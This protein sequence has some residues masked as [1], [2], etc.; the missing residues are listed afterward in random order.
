MV[1]AAV[2]SVAAAECAA[3]PASCLCVQHLNTLCCCYSA[4]LKRSS[5]PHHCNA[6][7]VWA[8]E[9]QP[10]AEG[11]AAATA[12]TPVVRPAATLQALASTLAAL[13]GCHLVLLRGRSPAGKPEEA[14][15][16]L[17]HCGRAFAAAVHLQSPGG[18]LP[19]RVGVMSTAEAAAAT[20]A[21]SGDP[22]S[23]SSVSL[24]A[25]SR[26]AVFQQLSAQA[27]AALEHFLQQSSN[28]GGGA[29]A[30][31]LE[32]LLLWLATCGDVF[33][34]RAAASDALL[35]AD[36][37]AGGAGLLPPLRRPYEGLGWEA[38]WAA[39][40]NPQLRSAEHL[41]TELA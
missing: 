18:L 40:L 13:P 15:T 37:A 35:L 30:S 6:D 38:L 7:A 14:S 28:C 20:A 39:A 16:V 24:W 29:A 4:D 21:G 33:T 26:H 17:L 27:A 22:L 3:G 5:S 36:P 31:A 10:Q 2:R 41:A 23:G 19:L 12:T 1:G 32:L 34:R 25:P 9:L 11:A 8:R